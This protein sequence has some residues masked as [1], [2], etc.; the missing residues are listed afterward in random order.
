MWPIITYR[1][2]RS[3]GPGVAVTP[4]RA[5]DRNLPDADGPYIELDDGSLYGQPARLHVAAAIRG[6]DL[7]AVFHA[8]PRTGCRRTPRPTC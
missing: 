5:W 3:S 8:L 7:H 6:E 1:P 2:A 4:G